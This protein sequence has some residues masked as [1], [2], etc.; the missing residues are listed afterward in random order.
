MEQYRTLMM[1]IERRR[2]GI[3]NPGIQAHRM[4]RKKSPVFL[5]ELELLNKAVEDDRSGDQ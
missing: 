4:N 5:H 1:P 3:G 2:R